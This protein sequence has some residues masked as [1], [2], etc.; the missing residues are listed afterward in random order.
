MCLCRRNF[1]NPP[2]ED[3]SWSLHMNIHVRGMQIVVSI[4]HIYPSRMRT[5]CLLTV[6]QHALHRWGVLGGCLPWGCLPRASVCLGR[7]T[8][9]GVSAQGVCLPGGC[10]PR[11]CL[12]GGCLPWGVSAQGVSAQ[13]VSAQRGC[14]PLVLGGV[15][16]GGVCLWSQKGV[17]LWSWGFIPA[18]NGAATPLCG[19]TDACET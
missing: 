14:L 8:A 17:C 2:L 11:G 18:C 6:A 5:A 7:V 4:L 9:W 19:Q 12:P 10:L 16:P 1:G 3:S 13:G 15:C